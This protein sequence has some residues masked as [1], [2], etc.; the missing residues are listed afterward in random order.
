MPYPF[1]SSSVEGVTFNLSG[2][3]TILSPISNS[4]KRITLDWGGITTNTVAP[5][6]GDFP[7]FFL[8][9]TG[10]LVTTGY[11]GKGNALTA[12]LVLKGL[13]MNVNIGGGNFGPLNG[14]AT[15]IEVDSTNHIYL[16]TMFVSTQG[17]INL[18][19]VTVASVT[20]PDVLSQISVTTPNGVGSFTA[21]QVRMV[22][23]G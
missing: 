7:T 23:E 20:L 21:G 4:A 16:A 15:L 1:P 9:T 18:S 6:A 14:S 13:E 8:G 19:G 11:A 12:I 10:G 22:V 3:S 5:G 17:T 2:T